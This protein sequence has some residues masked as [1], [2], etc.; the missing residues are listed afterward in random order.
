M[1]GTAGSVR[2]GLPKRGSSGGSL[3]KIFKM[4]NQKC[5]QIHNKIF[6]FVIHKNIMCTISNT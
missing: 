1:V 6:I 2:P 4:K 5:L 3:E